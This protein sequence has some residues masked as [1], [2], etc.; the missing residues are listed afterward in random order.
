MAT[1]SGG[2]KLERALQEMARQVS[3]PAVLRVGFLGNATYPDGKSVALIAALQEFGTR[4][5]PPRP[6]FRNMIAAKSSGW[7]GAVAANLRANNY[8][9]ERSLEDVGRAIADQLQMSIRDLTSP[10]LAA[11]TIARKG[12]DK[13][14]IET[15]QMLNSVDYE[16]TVR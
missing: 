4:R 16:V 3:K 10:P 1:I 9:A 12:F 6:F 13:P 2:D 15:T 11:S 7:P 8:D 14:L 5:M